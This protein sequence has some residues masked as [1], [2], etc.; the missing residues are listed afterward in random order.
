MSW[1][2]LLESFGAR[3]EVGF[4]VDFHQHTDFSAGVDVAADESFRRFA[5]GFLG[6]GRLA[7]FAKHGDGF[8]D[9]SAGFN[10]S[11]TAIVETRVG[12]VPQFLYELGWNFHGCIRCTHPFLSLSAVF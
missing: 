11:R 5:R 9:V 1:H 6:G 3:D 10:Q 4:A 8:F 12:A 2:K 7:L